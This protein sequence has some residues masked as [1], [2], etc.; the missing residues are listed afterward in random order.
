[1]R[2]Y[3][4]HK[5]RK[6]KDKK[7]RPQYNLN[8]DPPCELVSA[9]ENTQ[10]NTHTLS[11]SLS[12]TLFSISLSLSLSISLSLYFS[13]GVC[14]S[15]AVCCKVLQCVAMCCSVWCSSKWYDKKPVQVT[16]K[17]DLHTSKE[18][19]KHRKRPTNIKRDL[20][21]RPTYIWRDINK[22][23]ETYIHQKRPA[24]I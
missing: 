10:M 19:N 9:S 13:H 21:K 8:L 6:M 4:W 11:L 1:V 18:T 3:L 20:D 16:C 23:K 17:R 12:P 14:C 2:A 5:N 7:F 24:Y 22:S 15:V